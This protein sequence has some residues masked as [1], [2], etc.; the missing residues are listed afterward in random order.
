MKRISISI[1][2]VFCVF[3]LVTF[4]HAQSSPSLAD[5]QSQIQ[6]LQEQVQSLQQELQSVAAG[7]QESASNTKTE[8]E[9][10]EEEDEEETEES[11]ENQDEQEA[12]DENGNG[13]PA[14]VQTMFRGIQGP[15]VKQLQKV[16]S[17]DPKVY[18]EGL[19]T[20]Y[21]G[22]MTEEALRKFQKQHNL[23]PTGIVDSKTK[24]V[25]NTI[26]QEGAG[27]SGT[28]PPGLLKKFRGQSMLENLPD[29]ADARCK[30]AENI[31]S[32]AAGPFADCPEDADGA[33]DEDES[34][35]AGDDN[36]SGTSTDAS[37][38]T[39]TNSS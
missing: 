31:P 25:I 22:K 5:L 34:D 17:T 21:F 3:G 14:F 29:K 24:Q 33:G 35:A 16:L 11:E 12:E 26:L 18:P 15:Q 23:S 19:Q 9:G 20:G 6:A 38:G 2:T 37:S 27:K 30:A 13:P 4:A 32:A 28:V 1:V 8:T 36:M 7:V 39:S 10:A